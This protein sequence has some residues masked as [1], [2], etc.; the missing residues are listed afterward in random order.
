MDTDKHSSESV[1]SRL[2]VDVVE[3]IHR[4]V[5]GDAR[6]EDMV[7]DYVEFRWKK[8]DL[9]YIPAAAATQIIRRPADFLTAAKIYSEPELFAEGQSFRTGPS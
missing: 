7:L 8:R 4:L 2:P 3:H 6:T 9:F 1:P 5:G